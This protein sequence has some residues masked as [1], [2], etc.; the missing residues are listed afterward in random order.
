MGSRD[1]QRVKSTEYGSAVNIK[2][3]KY[4]AIQT[5]QSKRARAYQGQMT[6]KPSSSGMIKINDFTRQKQQANSMRPGT[7]G[8]YTSQAPY[9]QNPRKKR[10]NVGLFGEGGAADLAL[11]A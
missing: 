4:D 5:L 6:S 1:S 11:T 8:N 7:V 9:D 2:L 10:M 3:G